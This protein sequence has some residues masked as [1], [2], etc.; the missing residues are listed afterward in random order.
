METAAGP[1][2][3][4]TIPVRPTTWSWARKG[5]LAIADQ[6]LITSSNFLVALMLARQVSPAEYGAYAVSFEVFLLLA[7][8]YLA[9][10][11]EPISIFGAS[12]YKDCLREYFGSMLKNQAWV[13]VATLLLVGSAAVAIHLAHGSQTLVSALAGVAVASPCVLLFW[14]ARRAFYIHL[15]P[16]A[17]L[18]GAVLYSST[19]LIGLAV[20]SRKH[21]LSP[22]MVFVLMAAGAMVTS[23]VLLWKLKPT[24]VR[25]QPLGEIVRRHWNYGCWALASAGAS[26][27]MS[28]V[29][30]IAIS[31]FHGLAASGE[32]RALMNLSAPAAQGFTAVSLLSLP[33]ASRIYDNRDPAEIR[34]LSLRL[35]ALYAGGTAL[36][37]AVVIGLG[38]LLLQLLYQGKYQSVAGLIPWLRLAMVLRIGA[39]AQALLLRAVQSPFLVFSAYGAATVV[40]VIAGIP[41]TKLFGLKGAIAAMIAVGATA[42]V[43]SSVLLRSRLRT[44]EPRG[45]LQAA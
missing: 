10:I 2:E 28:A 20:C 26:W 25:S 24:L 36:Y 29:F 18:S 15:A 38:P 30:Y 44:I 43:V 22:L 9:F 32:M 14:I 12:T 33:Y 11:L 13:T 8:V 41:A 6:G 31:G 23:M 3:S 19:L 37:F 4:R 1:A 35:I 7:A 27:A 42:L 16:G 45:E 39:T 17:A 40:A 34:R 21:V 5:T